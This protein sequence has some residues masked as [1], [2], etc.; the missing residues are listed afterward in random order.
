MAKGS[1]CAGW[2]DK[3]VAALPPL[4]DMDVNPLG[5][6]LIHLSVRAFPPVEIRLPAR[7]SR[8]I[9]VKF[10]RQEP[11]TCCGE[12]HGT[13]FLSSVQ[14]PEIKATPQQR[15]AERPCQ[16]ISPLCPIE[17]ATGD[18]MPG[19]SQLDGLNPEL[20]RKPL[21]AGRANRKSLPF[22]GSEQHPALQRQGDRHTQF[23]R[24]MVIASTG[25]AERIAI[26]TL[27]RRPWRRLSIAR[28]GKRLEHHCNLLVG[29]SIISVPTFTDHGE[30]TAGKQLCQMLARAS[31]GKPGCRCELIRG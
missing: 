16:V 2:A 31:S 27:R 15:R 10:S 17:A 22:A 26:F 9:N 28:R 11:R 29:E 13:V 18:D 21:C 7:D 5:R 25:K 19:R 4:A 8:A 14:Q 23:T 3:V 24:E 30:K 12:T 1:R 20:V 6:V